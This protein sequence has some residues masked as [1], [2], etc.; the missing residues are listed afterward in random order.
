MWTAYLLLNGLFKLV[1][2][3]TWLRWILKLALSPPLAHVPVLP[4]LRSLTEGFLYSRLSSPTPRLVWL[5]NTCFPTG[6]ST[7]QMIDDHAWK[8]KTQAW[9][10]EYIADVRRQAT[11]SHRC[12]IS[13]YFVRIIRRA[14]SLISSV[15][16]G[17][18]APVR[19]EARG[20][21][22]TLVS[23]QRGQRSGRK[24]EQR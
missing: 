18:A 6:A 13:R 11:K 20:I 9:K 14:R 22:R 15:E 24:G 7:R 23:A 2:F 19:R 17:S 16:E 8:I 1:T 4:P 21:N 12:I 3:C 5:W 10:V